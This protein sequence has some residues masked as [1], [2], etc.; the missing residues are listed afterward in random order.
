[1]EPTIFKAC[2]VCALLTANGEYNDGTDAA[3][4]CVEGQQKL[5]GDKSSGFMIAGCHEDC[6]YQND[7]DHEC[8]EFEYGFSWS[9]CEGCGDPH[10]GDRYMLAVFEN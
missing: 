4:K 3:E 2:L 5:W 6:R 9:D 7:D 8:Q 10:G 1:M